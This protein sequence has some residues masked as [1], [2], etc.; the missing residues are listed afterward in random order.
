[1]TMLLPGVSIAMGGRQ[2]TVPPLTLGQ[3]RR[4]LPK[5]RQL[6]EAAATPGDSDID[7]LVEIVTEA[8]SR[9]YPDVTAAAV[10]SLL[11]IG[12]A[13]MVLNAVLAGSGLQS[14]EASAVATSA[15]AQSTVCSPPPAATAIP[16]SMR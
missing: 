13:G 12:N 6:T 11:D 7:L 2:W 3:L 9:N 4:L 14:G 1:M 16:S 15:G 10:E 5:L 8:L